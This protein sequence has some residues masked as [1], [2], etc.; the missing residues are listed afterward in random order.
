MAK[1]DGG[2]VLL[3]GCARHKFYR[4]AGRAWTGFY[5]SP[6]G[7]VTLSGQTLDKRLEAMRTTYKEKAVGSSK[8]ED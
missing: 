2:T 5:N 8:V 1:Y 3:K 4:V 7:F 6:I